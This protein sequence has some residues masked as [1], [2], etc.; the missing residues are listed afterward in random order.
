[1]QLDKEFFALVVALEASSIRY[2][3]AGG[4]ALA[5]HASPRFTRDMDVVVVRQDM[6]KLRGVLAVLQYLPSA[7][8]WS[9][10][11]GH[12]SLA[13]FLKAST[14]GDHMIIDVLI[15]DSREAEKLVEQSLVVESDNGNVRIVRKADLIWMKTLRG[16]AQD[17]VDIEQL[18]KNGTD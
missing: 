15:T 12:F 1:M 8:E 9:F 16:S 11:S 17:L 10:R 18:Q 14:D 13:R 5:W 6:E 4:I 2:A 3:V 7:P